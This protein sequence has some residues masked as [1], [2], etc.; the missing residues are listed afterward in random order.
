MTNKE[1]EPKIEELFR[2]RG[3][4]EIKDNEGNVVE[5]LYQ[6]VVGDAD[7]QRARLAALKAS[8]LKRRAL[9]DKTSDDALIDLPFEDDYTHE[10]LVTL[11]IFSKYSTF[12]QNAE[13]NIEEKKV[14][15]PKSEATLEEQEEYITKVEE[16][17][18]EYEEK[19]NNRIKEQGEKLEAELKEKTVEELFDMYMKE[20][21]DIIC[22]LEMIKVF[23]EYATFFG[24][25]GDE[26]FKER[27]F[28]TIEAFRDLSPRV[29]NQLLQNYKDLEMNLS[30]VKK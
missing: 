2:W 27:R 30:D 3:K 28:T 23:D 4:V 5:T 10:E 14:K 6:R 17:K 1:L 15:E 24:T 18:K 19:V 8:K 22:R 11:I 25:Y 20:H 13:F 21:I 9:K 7:I 16:A 29:K 12:R 26:K